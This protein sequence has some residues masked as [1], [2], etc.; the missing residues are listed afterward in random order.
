MATGC[1]CATKNRF[2]ASPH[3]ADVARTGWSWGTTAFDFDLDGDR[4]IYV[5]NGFRS[6]ESSQDYCTNYWTHDIYTGDSNANPQ[7]ATFFADSMSDLNANAISWNGYEHN[8]LLMNRG[9]GGFMNVA[10]LFGVAFEYDSRAVVGADLDRDGRPDLLVADY[11]YIG[12]G[13]ELSL[14]VF[15]NVLETPNRWIG[16][17]LTTSDSNRTRSPIGAK[18]TVTTDRGRQ[19]AHYVTGDSFLAQHPAT[20]HFGLG[21][22][23]VESVQIRWPNGDTEIATD[24]D[25]DQY[26]RADQGFISAMP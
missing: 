1:S 7:L 18:V 2:V 24:V 5:A 10:H 20:L 11:Q 3:S 9:D 21:S 17:D 15:R 4:D 16:V 6:G 22:S 14:H 13:F 26:I 8:S 23:E 19:V 12:H 25:L